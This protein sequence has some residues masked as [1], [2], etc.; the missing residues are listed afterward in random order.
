MATP[1]SERAALR[2]DEAW[3]Q[4]YKH[5]KAARV[6]DRIAGEKPE[7]PLSRVLAEWMAAYEAADAAAEAAFRALA[8]KEAEG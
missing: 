6:W 8:A 1:L 3:A 4:R 5:G 2:A 7:D